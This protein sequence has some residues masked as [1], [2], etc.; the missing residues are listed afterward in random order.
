[1]KRSQI[2][3]YLPPPALTTERRVGHQGEH[4]ETAENNPMTTT[5]LG[6]RCEK[7]LL[8]S[9]PP[10]S[11]TLVKKRRRLFFFFFLLPCEPLRHFLGRPLTPR[12]L[13]TLLRGIGTES[14]KPERECLQR[15]EPERHPLDG[16]LPHSST[17]P[18]PNTRHVHSPLTP[19][20]PPRA[21]N[22]L[23]LATRLKNK[24]PR[25]NMR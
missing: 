7:K 10:Q 21:K 2:A 5:N 8:L 13:Q 23:H 16:N 15:P 4:S 25:R 18:P 17:D 22:W 6:A 24:N 1:M 19:A 11:W 20:H 12:K 9:S 3:V 14:R